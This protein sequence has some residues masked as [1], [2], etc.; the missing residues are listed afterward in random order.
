MTRYL[1]VLD[2]IG[3]HRAIMPRTGGEPALRDEGL[4]ESAVM[5]PQMAAYY[6]HADLATQAALL[7]SGV[8]LAHA[9]VDGNKRTAELAGDVFL[10]LN[11]WWLDTE[12]LELALQIEE[13]VSLTEC[14]EQAV[15]EF[16][17]WIEPRLMPRLR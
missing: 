17:Q 10:Q 11:G 7:I 13:V 2:V 12:P 6:E 3:L 16:A 14:R 5:R 4:L 15:K 8:V 9:F 1:T